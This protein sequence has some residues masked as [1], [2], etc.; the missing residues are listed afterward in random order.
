MANINANGKQWA[1]IVTYCECHHNHSKRGGHYV[2]D[3]CPEFRK[4]EEDMTPEA[5]ICV[6][7]NC[8]RNYHRREKLSVAMDP[9]T[10][11]LLHQMA[12]APSPRAHVPVLGVQF[13]PVSPPPPPE[14]NLGDG[15]VVEDAGVAES[16]RRARA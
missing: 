13:F 16:R 9:A 2:V 4:V 6:A 5:L 10:H 7:Y 12:T 14:E 1:T 11:H 8:H 3:G 15:E